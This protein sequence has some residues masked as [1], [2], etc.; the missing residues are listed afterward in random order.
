MPELIQ[1]STSPHDSAVPPILDPG[2][3]ESFPV[4]RE[5]FLLY[6]SEP[7]F[8]AALRTAAEHFFAM[9]LE[10]YDGWPE[11]P[12]SSTRMELRALAAD[13]RHAQGFAASIGQERN[14][15]TLPSGDVRLSK[16][17]AGIARLLNQVATAIERKLARE[18]RS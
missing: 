6:I 12:E 7:G 5:S 3:W 17:A 4:F 15:S 10:T 14:L 9:V 13:L 18:V 11:W 8:N 2:L 1:N 16:H